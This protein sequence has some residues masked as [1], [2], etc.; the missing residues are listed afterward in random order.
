MKQ[1]YKIEI[2]G[3]HGRID[4]MVEGKITAFDRL[5]LFDQLANHLIG[6]SPERVIVAT[7]IAGGGIA[8]ITGSEYGKTTK[9]DLSHLDKFM[10]DNE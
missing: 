5:V 2:T 10:K 7:T 4:M 3:Y 1:N 8:K 6:D 9:V